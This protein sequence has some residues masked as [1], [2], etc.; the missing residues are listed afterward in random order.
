MNC[1]QDKLKAAVQAFDLIINEMPESEKLFESSKAGIESVLRTS[2]TVGMSVLNS[3]LNARE[4]ELKEPLAK[5]VYD[6]LAGLT[7]DDLLSCQRK[8]IRD[9]AYIYGILGNI[10]DLDMRFLRS[11]GPV[12]IVSLDELF[13]FE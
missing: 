1:R 3:Y 2:R 13:G 6:K 5:T 4:L 11:L 8:W 10:D 9:R 7:M 12:Q